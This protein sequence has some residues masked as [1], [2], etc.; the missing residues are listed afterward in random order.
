[1]LSQPKSA[2]HQQAA[3]VTYFNNTGGTSKGIMTSILPLKM[4]TDYQNKSL[5]AASFTILCHEHY[6]A[7]KNE[8]NL[9]L[10]DASQCAGHG[11]ST[12]LRES[13][14]VHVQDPAQ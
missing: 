11:A 1:M 8:E 9:E 2:V 13:V 5:S 3:K 4:P 12:L 7:K 14:V 10:V 6:K